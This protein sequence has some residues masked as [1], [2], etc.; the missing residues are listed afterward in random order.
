MALIIQYWSWV[1]LTQ[2]IEWITKQRAKF[3]SQ[4]EFSVGTTIILSWSYLYLAIVK[5]KCIYSFINI[6]I[7][8]QSFKID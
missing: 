5:Y 4:D 2:N 7:I 3:A 6:N 1:L 8:I